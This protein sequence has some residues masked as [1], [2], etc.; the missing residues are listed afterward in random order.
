MKRH[1]VELQNSEK[2]QVNMAKAQEHSREQSQNIPLQQQ[3]GGGVVRRKVINDRVCKTTPDIQENRSKKQAATA[4]KLPGCQ[5]K[6]GGGILSLLQEELADVRRKVS[7]CRTRLGLNTLRLSN[8][9]KEKM[10]L[11][12]EVDGLRDE[13]RESKD[14]CVRSKRQIHRLESTQEQH[15]SSRQHVGQAF[16]MRLYNLM[17]WVLGMVWGFRQLE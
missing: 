4:T 3:W 5:G 14:R 6:E 17:R 1:Y 12:K 7:A 11:Q 9:V 15:A 16:Y 8:Q 13:L 10:D 2:E